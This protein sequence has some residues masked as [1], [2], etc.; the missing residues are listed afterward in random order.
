MSYRR[1]FRY[2]HTHLLLDRSPTG[3]V[4]V[5][6][7]IF[8]RALRDGRAYICRESL[9]PAHGFRFWCDG[10]AP[11][12]MGEEA[13]SGNGKRAM[14]VELPRPARIRLL[15][16]GEEVAHQENATSLE[17]RD[18]ALPGGVPAPQATEKTSFA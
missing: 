6:R 17:R 4:A 5:D 14:R 8:Y 13:V 11:L 10:A 15:R 2:L 12:T 1:S 16:D 18:R 3:D 7:D 9:A